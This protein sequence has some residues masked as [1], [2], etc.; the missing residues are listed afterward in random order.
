MKTIANLWTLMGHPIAQ[1]EWPLEWKLDAIAEAGFDGVCW[2]PSDELTRGAAERGLIFVGGMASGDAAAFPGILDDLK[3]S[4]TIDV[5][6]Q[7][8]H[9]ETSTEEALQLTLS[10]MEL[11]HSLGL[12]PA[13]ETHRGT[14]TETPEKMYALADAYEHATGEKLDISWDFSHF[15]V[16]KHLLPQDFERRLLVRPDLIQ[17]SVQ[18]HFRP[19]N[20]HHVQVPITRLDGS[21]TAEAE[22]WRPFGKAVMR[23]WLQGN[24]DSRRE[25]FLCPELGPVEGGYAL[26]SFPNSWED[27]KRLREEIVAMWD[28]VVAEEPARKPA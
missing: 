25:M 19:F 26:E 22:A 28:E 23:L 20:G 11:A 3:R 5:N 10:L 7:L 21:L 9:D 13:I 2:G 27:A 15:A 1:A 16:V 14:C 4:G 12:R 8:A 6:V 24:H 18:F 17:Q